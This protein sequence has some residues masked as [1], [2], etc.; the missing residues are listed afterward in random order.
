MLPVFSGVPQGSI[1]GSTLFVLFL[2]DIVSV[3]SPDNNIL[4]Y[5]DDTKIWRQINNEPGHTA[6]QK[7]IN[8][9]MDWAVRNKLIFHLSKIKVLMVSKFRPPLMDILPLVQLYYHMVEHVLDN[10]NSQ[11]DLGVLINSTL[12]F[13]EQALSLY[14]KANQKLGILN[15]TCHFVKS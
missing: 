12:N 15:I 7:D 11:K 14:S 4:M 9:L 8:S 1:L 2:N 10:V 13:T 3:I 5:A 6:L